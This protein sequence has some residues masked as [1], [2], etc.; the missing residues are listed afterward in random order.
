[1]KLV[2]FFIAVAAA[3][4]PQEWRSRSVYVLL[5]DRFA[6]TESSGLFSYFSAPNSK[7]CTDLSD[8]C[9]GTWQGLAAKLDHIKSMG[10]D[11]IWISPV[12]KNT[13]KGYHGY[14]A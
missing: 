3:A 14:W 12:E 11:A 5:T 2:A 13:E 9:G 1:M 6:Q 10:F 7:K 4:R 8:Y